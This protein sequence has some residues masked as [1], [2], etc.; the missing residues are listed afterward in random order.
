[1]QTWS[2]FQTIVGLSVFERQVKLSVSPEASGLNPNLT[3]KFARER[4][5][6][7]ENSPLNL[8]YERGMWTEK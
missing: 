1:M 5:A 2:L 8:A 6:I 3:E 7:G 4:Q